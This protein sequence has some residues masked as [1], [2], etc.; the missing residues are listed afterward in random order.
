[1][2][3]KRFFGSG[4][5]LGKYT[6]AILLF[7]LSFRGSAVVRGQELP[8][9]VP[10]SIGENVQSGTPFDKFVSAAQNGGLSTRANL[11]EMKSDFEDQDQ[12]SEAAL[13]VGEQ[14][15][16]P[17]PQGLNPDSLKLLESQGGITSDPQTNADDQTIFKLAVKFFEQVIFKGDAEFA[18]RPKFNEGMDISG[19][20]TFDKDTAGYAII[21]KGNQ[22]VVVDF[23]EKYDDP[24][25]VTASLYIQP[26]KDSEV[27][28]AAE[29]L[30]LIS[31]GKYVVTNVTEKGF[32]IMMDRIA[33]SDVP[34]SWHALAVNNPKTFKKKG[35][36]LKGYG[37]SD[38]STDISNL[39]PS[40]D[41]SAGSHAAGDSASP[42]RPAAPNSSGPALTS[43]SP[44]NITIP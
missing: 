18:K 40:G 7:F 10:E 26:Y 2:E 23:D 35:N 32:E 9:V 29:D 14:S 8:L 30:L 6:L 3:N 13:A 12:T 27:G 44:E 15:P 5:G 11:E 25:V 24:P 16:A 21:K 34:F 36:T 31:D 33:D 42:S 17:E 41:S 38:A 22:S 37:A 28:A 20:P 43:D 4:R 19:T 1:M 39:N